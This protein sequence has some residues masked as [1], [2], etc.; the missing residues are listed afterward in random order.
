MA[1]VG[2]GHTD[3]LTIFIGVV[4]TTI[5]AIF[6]LFFAMQAQQKLIVVGKF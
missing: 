5:M 1:K 3:Y 4:F 6:F 2:V